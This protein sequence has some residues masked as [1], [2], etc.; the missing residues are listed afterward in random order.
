MVCVY[1]QCKLTCTLALF[2]FH[3]HRSA[4]FKISE[5]VTQRVGDTD[6][7]VY[8]QCINDK[9]IFEYYSVKRY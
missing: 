2:L 9:M 4:G 8:N 6:T 5:I 3:F 7:I 1:A